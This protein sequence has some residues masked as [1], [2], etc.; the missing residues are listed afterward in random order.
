MNVA[1]Q[2]LSSDSSLFLYNDLKFVGKASNFHNLNDHDYFNHHNSSINNSIN[3]RKR[4]ENKY[5]DIF[6][7]CYSF[8]TLKKN[9]DFSEYFRSEST[10]FSKLKY[11]KVVQARR[12]EE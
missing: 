11:T 4:T 6:K 10:V 5:P 2:V 12:E 7:I 9:V 1:R 3:T 8:S